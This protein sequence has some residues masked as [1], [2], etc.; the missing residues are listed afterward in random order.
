[1]VKRLMD[2]G[3]AVNGKN[4][5]GNTALMIACMCI[6]KG[7]LDIVKYLIEKGADVN[8]R[9]VKGSTALSRARNCNI[10]N[11]NCNRNNA[12]ANTNKQLLV[13][14]IIS[15]ALVNVLIAAGGVE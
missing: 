10:N 12:N 15:C 5:D 3:A 8:L 13:N 7:Y 2:V 11:R 6:E 4:K 9:N 14:N 1:M